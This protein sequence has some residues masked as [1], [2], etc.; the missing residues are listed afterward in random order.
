MKPR[1]HIGWSFSGQDG[2]DALAG[3]FL[4]EGAARGERLMYV[5]AEPDPRA[6]DRLDRWLD[7]G[8]VQVASIAEVYG[9]SGIVDEVAQ[10]A[11]F[12]A[13][14]AEAQAQ[15]CSGIRV[16][17]DNTPLVTDERR[18]AAWLRW[19]LMADRFMS[20]NRVTGLCAFDRG[21]VSMD[22]LRHLATLHPLS[23]ADTPTPQY[24]L[25]SEAGTLRIEGTIDLFTIDQLRLALEVLPDDTAVVIDL[26]TATL[27]GSRPQAGLRRLAETGVSV[28]IRGLPAE[29]EEL[30]A[31]GLA[32][33]GR[34]VLQAH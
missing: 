17:A 5:L 21:L 24:R 23:S 7:P 29:L 33:T 19:E 12:T 10:R 15:G 9:A 11:T 25:F 4:A 22:R 8:L 13:A 32:V 14:L 2:L 1:D 6:A 18:L 16:A 26:D 30:A 27:T 20:E 31:T 28:T 34:L 3:P